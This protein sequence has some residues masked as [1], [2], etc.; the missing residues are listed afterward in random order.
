MEGRRSV[1]SAG[2]RQVGNDYRTLVYQAIR[3]LSYEGYFPSVEAIRKRL[4]QGA[5]K[6]IERYRDEFRKIHR[7]EW[8]RIEESTKNTQHKPLLTSSS[9]EQH[10]ERLRRLLG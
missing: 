1:G 8:K 6:T 4:R 3:A 10:D 9:A 2:G 5:K 7:D